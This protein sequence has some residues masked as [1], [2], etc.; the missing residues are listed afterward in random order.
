[1]IGEQ[2]RPRMPLD[3][4]LFTAVILILPHVRL[5]GVLLG[6]KILV[7]FGMMSF[8]LYLWHYFILRALGQTAFFGAFDAALRCS[9]WAW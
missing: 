1:M 9:R 2:S 5:G 8:D 6:G 7:W 3:T 4:L